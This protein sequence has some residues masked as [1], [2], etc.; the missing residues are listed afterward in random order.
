MMVSSDRIQDLRSRGADT[1]VHDLSVIIVS[2]NTRAVLRHCLEELEIEGEG[3]SMEVLLVDNGS[4]AGSPEMVAA[5]FPGGRL[6]DSRTDLGCAAA[7]D[8]MMAHA[9]GRDC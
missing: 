8:Q 1:Y 7:K 2:F 6:S 9:R 3:L 5:A 4:R